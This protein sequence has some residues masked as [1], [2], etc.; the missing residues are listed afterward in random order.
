[1]CFKNN[2]RLNEIK[3]SIEE[4][5]DGLKSKEHVR[6]IVELTDEVSQAVIPYWKKEEIRNNLKTLKKNLDD[7]DRAAKTAVANKVVD[8][9]KEFVKEHPD[10]PVLV[11][12]LKAFNNTKALDSA[13]KQVIILLIQEIEII[14]N[15]L[16]P[17]FESHYCSFVC[18]SRSGFQ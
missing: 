16:G 6:K 2:S 7:K 5:K 1:M 17:Y 3:S 8:E 9:I 11:K 13:L 18:L 14:M 10:L 4:D 12:E 15:F